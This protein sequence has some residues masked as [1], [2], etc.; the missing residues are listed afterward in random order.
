MFNFKKK[1]KEQEEQKV[2]MLIFYNPMEDDDS[3]VYGIY[4]SYELAD[5]AREWRKL[6]DGTYEGCREDLIY[7]KAIIDFRLV[8]HNLPK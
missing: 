1:K 2:W 6:K 5:K 4:S 3:D 8:D 7:K